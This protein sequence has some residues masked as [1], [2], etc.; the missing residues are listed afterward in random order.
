[1]DPSVFD[2]AWEIENGDTTHVEALKA[3]QNAAD[4]HLLELYTAT[5]PEQSATEAGEA[6]VHQ[7]FHH[8]LTQG[9]LERFYGPLPGAAPAQNNTKSV[10]LP[11]GAESLS[12]VR[13]MKWEIN[14]QVYED[15]LDDIISRAIRLLE[16]AQAGPSITGHGDAHNG[17]VFLTLS[18][19]AP[20]LLYFDPAFA[21]DHHPLLDLTKPLFHNVFAMWMYFPTEVAKR[22][23]IALN[24]DGNRF[25]VEH[26]YSLPPVREMFLESKVERVLTPILRKLRSAGQLRTDWQDY[27][28]A[29]LFCC[30]FLTMN[31]ADSTR[32]P[33]EVALLG[34][35]MAVEMGAWSAEKR[36]RID[37]MLDAVDTQLN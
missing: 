27:L 13:A 11:D 14:G 5:L 7:L 28:K 32:F 8:R 18:E 21:G 23:T 22:T 6:P 29:A 30:P 1:N 12:V 20:A 24:R 19:D 25:I 36:S 17:N 4:D 10:T 9:R 2:V 34:L 16:P 3:A 37:R 26:S 15:S 33:P 31:L 35:S